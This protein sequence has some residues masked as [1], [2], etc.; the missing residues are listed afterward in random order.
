L[1]AN[2]NLLTEITFSL[3]SG[4]QLEHLDIRSN[5][6]TEFDLELPN[7]MNKIN[8]LAPKIRNYLTLQYLP[9]PESPDS[10]DDESFKIYSNSI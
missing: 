1:I 10:S 2:K 8:H 6:L 3:P 9:A 5:K 7:S 4:N